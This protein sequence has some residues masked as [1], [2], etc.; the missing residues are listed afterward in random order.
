[1]GVDVDQ[2]LRIAAHE[3]GV[4]LCDPEEAVKHP[5]GICDTEMRRV[6]RILKVCCAL[7]NMRFE[8]LGRADVGEDWRQVDEDELAKMFG[9]DEDMQ[10]ACMGEDVEEAADEE[11]VVEPGVAGEEEDPEP[12]LG[13]SN[14]DQLRVGLVRHFKRH[15]QLL[16]AKRGEV[17]PNEIMREVLAFSQ[18]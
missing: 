9:D 3:G 14:L 11:D 7:H 10:C 16:R 18:R 5:V 17:H 8:A 6:D 2:G 1:V 15:K 13:L 4:L 12:E